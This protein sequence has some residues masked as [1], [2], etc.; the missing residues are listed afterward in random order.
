VFCDQE[1][2][3]SR[4]PRPAGGQSV[5]DVLDL[6]A[7]SASFYGR[8]HREIAFYGGTF[9]SLPEPRIKELL[10]TVAPYLEKGIV[11]SVRVSTRPDSLDEE[12]VALLKALGVGTVEVGAQSMDDGVLGKTRRGHSA[13]DTERAA[14]LLKQ[15][16]LRVGLQLMP[17]LPGDSAEK[18]S[19]TVKKAIRIKPDMVRLYPVVV[20]RGT[21]LALWAER[22]VYEPLNLEEAVGIC[23]ESCQQLETAGIPVIRI[24]LM[25]SP[26]LRER[27]QVL[28]G[29]WHESFGHLVRSEIYRRKIRVFLPGPGEAKK[30]CIRIPSKEVALLRGHKNEGLRR[31][32]EWTQASV[33]MILADDSLPPG[34]ITVEIP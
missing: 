14:I 5:R 17:G 30:I 18:F 12:K 26:S 33:G 21:E 28:S 10:G 8:K 19:A 2:I 25:N 22:G 6:A 7:R 13:E 16:G 20:I 9:A 11:H 31:I 24:G 15:Q 27:G 34:R 1:R 23:A 32:E 3:T 4:P 29:P